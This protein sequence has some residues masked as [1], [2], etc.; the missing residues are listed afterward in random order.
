MGGW[1]CHLPWEGCL[2]TSAAVRRWVLGSSRRAA[3]PG[4]VPEAL[5]P[6]AELQA[7]CLPTQ[8][9]AGAPPAI[10]RGQASALTS[11]RPRR[12]S[13]LF[14]R[15]DVQLCQLLLTAHYFSLLMRVP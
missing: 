2:C 10:R 12:F 9:Q 14:E 1:G 13:S 15:H 7:L 8:V 6:I 5:Y 4:S 3:V 11:S